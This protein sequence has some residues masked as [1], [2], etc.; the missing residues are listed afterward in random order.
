MSN[1]LVRCAAA[2]AAVAD[3]AHEDYDHDHDHDQC[4]EQVQDD[5]YY[6]NNG[7]D[8]GLGHEDDGDDGQRVNKLSDEQQQSK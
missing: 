5:Y 7:R 3:T 8:T 6:D 2:C 1:R 4:Q